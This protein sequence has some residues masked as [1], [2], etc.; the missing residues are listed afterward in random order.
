MATKKNKEFADLIVPFTACPFEKVE[1]DCP[2]SD[3]G[4][5]KGLDEILKLIDQLPDEKLISLREHHK[6]CQEWKIEKG[7]AIVNI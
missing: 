5:L 1:V 4:N 2:F 6:T 7:E 3:F